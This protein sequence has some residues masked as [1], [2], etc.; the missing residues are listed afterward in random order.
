MAA[1]PEEA[2]PV[3]RYTTKEFAEA[4]KVHPRTVKR[5]VRDGKIRSVLLTPRVRR[6]EEPEAF[7]A[8]MAS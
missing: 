1:E 6:L 8:R 4:I 2:T 3:Y 7:Q 5:L